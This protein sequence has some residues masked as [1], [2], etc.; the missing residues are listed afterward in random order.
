MT[1]FDLP[2]DYRGGGVFVDWRHY[3]WLIAIV[4]SSIFLFKYFRANPKNARKT[5]VIMSWLLIIATWSWQLIGVL[6]QD[7]RPI[8][9]VIPWHMCSIS[10]AV[11]PIVV[12]FNIKK[13]AQPVYLISMMGAIATFAFVEYF[14][15]KE[16]HFIFYQGII[17]HTLLFLI[18]IV[19]MASGNFKLEPKKIWQVIVYTLLM[20]AIGMFANKIVFAGYDTNFMYLEKSGFP[21]E[22]GGKYYFGLYVIIY[23]IV[24]TIIYACPILWN[25]FKPPKIPAQTP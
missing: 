3:L 16:M 8:W 20:L 15:H 10:G 1:F 17:Q 22:F 11:L 18:P 12:L 14:D 7:T 19:E 4:A 5:V 24:L 9:H 2:N 21:N 6:F 25:K 23:F 13:I